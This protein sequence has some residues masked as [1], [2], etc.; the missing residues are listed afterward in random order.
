MTTLFW[1]ELHGLKPAAFLI[2]G[3]TLLGFAYTFATEFPDSDPFELKPDEVAGHFISTVF[4][5]F[6]IGAALL[7]RESDD[8][9]LAFLD[10]LPVSR[11]LVFWT[12]CAAGWLVLSSAQLLDLTVIIICGLLSQSSISPPFP[13]GYAGAFV[14]LSLV[15]GA[16]GL[17]VAVALSFFRRWF[18]F[19]LGFLVLGFLWALSKD[20]AWVESIN[21]VALAPH[22]DAGK[23]HVPWGVLRI[24]AGVSAAALAVAW[25]GFQFL[26]PRA[27]DV[28]D[29]SGWVGRWIGSLG[30]LGTPLVWVAVVVCL[31]QLDGSTPPDTSGLAGETVFAN[32]RTERY[33]LLFRESQRSL[34]KPLLDTI[35]EVYD[36][37]VDFFGSPGSPDR[38]VVDFASPVGAHMAGMAAWSKIRL[39]LHADLPEERVRRIL[40]HETAHVLMHRLGGPL[41]YKNHNAT[42]FFNEGMATVVENELFADEEEERAE[43]QLA[44]AVWSRGPVPFATLCDDFDLT[45]QRDP[46]IVYPLGAVFGQALIEIHGSEAPGKVLAQFQ[47]PRSSSRSEGGA[48]WRDV[49]QACGYNLDR[50]VAEYEAR[51]ARLQKDEAAFLA[52]LPRLTATIERTDAEIILRPQFQPATKRHPGALVLVTMPKS[53]FV[54]EP[55]HHYAGEDGIFRI[56][57]TEVA[58][59]TLQYMLGWRVQGLSLPVFEPW[60]TAVLERP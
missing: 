39:P 28:I 33:H 9:T 16:Y 58:G 38:V 46:A 22:S 1:K 51:L 41:F 11:A 50:V 2:V 44:A 31:T 29:R 17:S 24:Q 52:T 56:R 13:W 57:R 34:V 48:L 43:G 54:P 15:A 35:D 18:L 4:F 10:A 8:G 3:I 53:G 26:G 20:H 30:R 27:R 12:K 45:K 32:E 37:V 40:G 21:P 47:H 59:V 36:D 6:V 49:L 5:A 14:A 55:T 25:V 7:T 19:A 60:T 42:R 23:T